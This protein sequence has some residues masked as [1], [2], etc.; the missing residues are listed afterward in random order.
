MSRGVGPKWLWTEKDLDIL[1]RVIDRA[2]TTGEVVRELRARIG[3]DG[4]WDAIRG[5][6]I[7]RLGH[8]NIISTLNQNRRRNC[9]DPK[10]R[11][12]SLEARIDALLTEETREPE[13]AT[14][15]STSTRELDPIQRHEKRVQQRDTRSEMEDLVLQL[16][17]A[18]KRQAFLD[19][20]AAH[21]EPPR[22]ARHEKTSRVREVAAVVLLSDLHV[23]CVV[24][25]D[26]VAFRNEYNLEIADRRLEK[27]LQ[28]LI[29]LI[30]HHRASGKVALNELVLWF[31]GDMME[32]FIHEENLQS[33][34]LSPTETIRWLKPR[35][36]NILHTLRKVLD[37][38]ITVPCDFGNHGR[39]TKKMPVATAYSN[40]YEWL[41]Y[42][43]LAEEFAN[44]PQ[45]QFDAG[46]SAHHYVDVLGWMC[47][48]HH[49][50]EVKY[51]GG[52]G[53]LGIPLL[54]RVPMWERLTPS[55]YH[56]IGHHHT[57]RLY[58]RTLVNG[59]LKGYDDF[60]QSIGADYEDPQQAFA[61]IDAHRGMSDVRPIWVSD[62]DPDKAQTGGLG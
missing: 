2:T 4:S 40:S 38:N 25:P 30:E 57:F 41:M 21:R 51:Q 36:R 29:W 12:A 20:M 48:F 11:A 17:E 22:I 39:S 56:F 62:E 31:G 3:F 27:F 26:A 50:H 16:K 55:H 49:G 13:E 5:A 32:G 43:D 1:Q 28:G 52:V 46:P 7:K 23:E 34:E 45:I 60:A 33:N 24:R 8:K 47:H 19:D 59:S 42:Q 10:D 44:E 54:K 9:L 15:G 14:R 58:G 37:I 61:L 6:L 35:L 18:R 53:G